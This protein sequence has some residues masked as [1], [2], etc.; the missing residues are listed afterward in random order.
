MAVK[1]KKPTTPGQRGMIVTD[2]SGLDKKK[3]EKSL[4]GILRRNK[5]RSHGKITVRHKGGGSKRKFRDI[6]FKQNQMGDTLTVMALEYDPNRSAFIALARNQDGK[7]RY[8]LAHSKMKTGDEVKIS[9]SAS[10]KDGNRMLLVNIPIG[11]LVHNIEIKAGR[12]GQ[13][14]RSAGSQAKVLAHDAGQT[15]LVM[16]SSEVRTVPSQA[17]ATVGVVSNASYREEVVGKAGRNRLRGKRPHVRGSAMNPVD[18]PHGGGEGRAP[19]GL[20]YPK[21]PWGKNA[22]GVKTRKRTKYSNISIIKRRKKKKKKR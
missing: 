21:T 2:Y 12:G 4:S 5:G 8:I 19:I 16:P 20:K 18:H 22:Y 7:K 9:E 1:I 6:D 15:Q 10:I 11:T 13:L 17:L 14:A 3:P